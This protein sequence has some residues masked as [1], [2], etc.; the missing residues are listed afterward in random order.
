M[1]ARKF[2]LFMDKVLRL[3]EPLQKSFMKFCFCQML[4]HG[5]VAC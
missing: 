4:L 3:M 2:V 1:E 5:L